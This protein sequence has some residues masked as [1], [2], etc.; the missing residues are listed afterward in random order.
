[1][2]I[3]YYGAA[4]F[5]V[6]FGDT[7]LAFNPISKK[8]SFKAPKFGSDICLITTDHPDM[9]GEENAAVGSKEPFVISGPGEYEVGGVFVKGFDSKTNYAGSEQKNTIYLTTLEDIN[10]VFLGA[11]ADLEL[12]SEVQEVLGEADILFVPISGEGT[13]EPSDAYKLS[14][15][16]EAHIIVPMLYDDTTL[17]SFRKEE[18]ESGEKALE[19]L[20]VKKKD[21]V[22][23]E[24]DIVS[25][26]PQT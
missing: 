21:V 6:Q 4:C 24:G 14:L 18:G 19:K 1:M 3:T 11:L 26:T 13:L 22:E 25:L 2:V 16:S 5:K 17:R 7:V 9:N 10:L 20:T 8:S 15:R 12:P 23:R